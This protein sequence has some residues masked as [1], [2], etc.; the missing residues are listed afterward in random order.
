M[1]QLKRTLRTVLSRPSIGPWPGER[2]Q[3]LRRALRWW[4][5]LVVILVAVGVGVGV[6]WI[7]TGASQTGN[8]TQ[9]FTLERGNLVA[10]IAPTGE[11]YT[12][13]QAE[14]S[15]DVS[16]I[17][18]IELLVAAGQQVKARDVLAR[19]DPTT[20][21]RAVTQAEADLTVA[22]DNLE[23]AQNPHTELDL[24]RARLA[25]TQAQ[26]GL[27]DARANLEEAR[28]PYTEL[29]LIQA[30]LAVTQA[31]VALEDAK[32]NLEALR[33]PDTG[34]DLTQARLAVNQAET[35]LADAK[36]DLK[37]LLNPDIKAAQAAVRDA[38][39]ALKS[40]QNQLI[41]EENDTDNAERLRTLE[42]EAI[43]YRNNYREALEKFNEGKIN[44]QKLDWEYSN[45]LAAEEKLRAAQVGAEIALTNAQ[46]QVTKAEEAYQ[47]ALENLAELQ[48]GPD[49]LEQA[50]AKDQVT[51]AEYNLAK[52]Q[53]SLAEI[54]AGPDPSELTKAQDQVAEAE[55]NLAKAREDLTDIKVGSV[56]SELIKAQN[57][58][59]EA[60]YNLAKVQTDLAEM[61]AGPD[62]RDIEVAQAKV[63]SAQATLDEARVALKAATMTAPFDGTVI[64]VGTEVGDL[65]S[66]NTI[67]V[68]L[69][70]LS[71]LRVRAIVDETDISQVEIGQEVEITF[72]AFPGHRFRGQVL[73]VP[74]QGTLAQNILTYEVPTSLEGTEGVSL[75]PG[76]T[77]NLNIVVGRRENVLLV[78]VMAVQQ[79]E[80]G[81]V[82]TVQD[83]P[84]GPGVA[85]RVE[86][87]LSDG[88]YVEVVRGL[89]E[90]DC[91]VVDYRMQEEGPAGF[92]GFGAMMP[93][94][95]M[96]GGVQRVRP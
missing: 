17:P 66:S 89:N 61:E 95:R 19:I 13:R 56:P 87:G 1:K 26:T 29:D 96:P 62:P 27:D 80:E 83:S 6:L 46:N 30:R 3:R 25:V 91:V 54:E 72:D 36:E 15:F 21:E 12:P 16:K 34:L 76:M 84:K 18:L 39:T 22:Q 44:Q 69:A 67:V 49:A 58:V 33:N 41:V 35:D 52:A 75:K 50:R 28:T 81:N 14:L 42:Y 8:P 79:G 60:E 11:V 68:T 82:V 4:P 78:P 55:Y 10:A 47:E 51:Q 53:E 92:G 37:A 32:E 93:G 70:D 94:G 57:Q 2:I 73:E 90:G 71:N 77:A 23:K 65:V 88:M 48:S 9:V 24:I 63:V 86:A 85:T 5:A 40:A 59:A 43:W 31:E 20:L 7:R 64:S 74:L 38:A 45:M